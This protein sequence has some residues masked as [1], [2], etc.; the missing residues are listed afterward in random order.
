MPV[1]FRDPVFLARQ[2]MTSTTSA[3]GAT[4]WASAPAGWS[5]STRCSATRWATRP[6]PARLAEALQVIALLA[7]HEEP[8]SFD[9]R[10]YRLHEAKLLPRSPRPAGP[11]SWSAAPARGA[12][13]RCRPLRRR[14]ER[15]AAPGRGL[16]ATST[17]LDELIVARGGAGRT[18]GAR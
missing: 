15:R 13:Y 10:F 11:G 12:P 9:G 2:A 1:S 18:C 4:S 17:L 14:L 8:V 16:R 7:R 6:R 5:G 3:G